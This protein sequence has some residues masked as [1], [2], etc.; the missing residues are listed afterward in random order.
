MTDTAKV[1]CVH[2]VCLHGCNVMLDSITAVPLYLMNTGQTEF[3][4]VSLS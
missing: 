3:T 1:I 2:I 4:F